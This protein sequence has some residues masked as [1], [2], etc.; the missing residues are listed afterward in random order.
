MNS[1]SGKY[2]Y[3]ALGTVAHKHGIIGSNL[4]GQDIQFKGVIGTSIN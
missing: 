3:Y 4:C 2:T 1:L